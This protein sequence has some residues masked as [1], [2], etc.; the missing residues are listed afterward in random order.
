M[1][2]RWRRDSGEGASD[3]KDVMIKEYKQLEAWMMN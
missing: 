1:E 2:G 3:R